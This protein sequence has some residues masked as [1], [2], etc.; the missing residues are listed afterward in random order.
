MTDGLVH[1]E[2]MQKLYRAFSCDVTLVRIQIIRKKVTLVVYYEIVASVVIL[3]NMCTL[4]LLLIYTE[5]DEVPSLCK[6]IN[7]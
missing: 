5:S 4:T 7:A 1:H 3:A 6:I 2:T